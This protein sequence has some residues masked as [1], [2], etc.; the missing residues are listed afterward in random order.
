MSDNKKKIQI[1]LFWVWL[2]IL[3]GLGLILRYAVVG[4][5]FTSNLCFAIAGLMIIFKLMRVFEK[6]SGKSAK[7]L[8]GFLNICICVILILA[9]ITGTL[10][11]NAGFG[12]AF[13]SNDYI[14]V[15]GAA[16]HGTTPSLS[17]NNRIN[18]AYEYLVA[19]PDTICVVSGGKGEGEDISEA[20]CM[21][22]ELVSRG[23]SG[24]RIWLEDQATSTQENLKNSLDLIERRTGQRPGEIGVVTSEY[25]LYRAGL[26]AK[27]EGVVANGIPAT[28]TWLSLRLNYF[29]REI[30]A[31]WKYVVFGK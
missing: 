13:R 9:T 28:T 10:I 21:Y 27:D 26:V 7:D 5:G 12:E 2:V 17:L 14:V 15:L 11:V 8:R 31:V 1:D 6:N 20:Q 23:I 18:A 29:L 16:V 24:E 19:H 30:V 25:H 4:Y 22:N 3:L